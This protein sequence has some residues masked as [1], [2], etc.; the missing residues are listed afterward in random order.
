VTA[1]AADTALASAT[2]SRTFAR[3]GDGNGAA[4][5]RLLDGLAA[6]MR[7]TGYVELDAPGPDTN[8]VLHPV[9]HDAT[10]PYRRKNAPTFVVAITAL[11]ETPADI[12][13]AGYPILVRALAN[14]C[15][16]V[17]DHGH[18]TDGDHLAVHFITLEQGTA[19]VGP[20]ALDDS[21]LAT[22][23]ARLEPLASSRLVI[24]NEFRA[25]LD[26]SLRDG[27]ER[28]AQMLDA[29]KH[30][31]ALGLLPAPFPLEE[32]LPP[33]DFRHVQLLY[34]LG[35]LSYG[36][37]SIRRFEA[38]APTSEFWMSASGVDKTNLREIGR[39]I[40]L[41]RDYDAAADTMVLSV[42]EGVRP[43]RVS[44]D[45][46]EH[47]MIYR[48]HP[49]VGAV[50]HVHGWIDD[51]VATEINYPCGTLELATAVA[52]LVRTADHPAQAVVGQRNHGLTITGFDL[53]EIFSRVG[54]LISAR[55][56]MT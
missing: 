51:I 5:T 21:F 8:V 36:N 39:D 53:D 16:L 45:A 6:W 41:V 2:G 29:G 28:S 13:R 32:I 18:H 22:V 20:A 24:A 50:L 14:L 23:F 38:G 49:E 40:L 35:G 4:L 27:D 17:V 10:R 55:V 43:R 42:P 52:D 46:I 54:H 44:V 37:C 25:D 56:P 33:R 34:G 9:A 11:E 15:L 31:D 47:W 12:V 1:T 48:E 3:S 7:G 19:T 30:L 26:E